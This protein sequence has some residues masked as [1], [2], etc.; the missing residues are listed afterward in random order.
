MHGSVRCPEAAGVLLVEVLATDTNQ[1]EAGKGQNIIIRTRPGAKSRRRIR[2]GGKL[3]TGRDAATLD[4]WNAIKARIYERS[5]RR[6]EVHLTHRGTDPHHVVKRSQGGADHEDNVILLCRA[7]HEMTD[8]PYEKGRLVIVS[9][10][11]GRFAFGRVYLTHSV[12][13]IDQPKGVTR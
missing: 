10:G 11:G 12:M 9:I 2:S 13:R 7:A 3:A 5:G 6:C 8:L 1:E 4:G